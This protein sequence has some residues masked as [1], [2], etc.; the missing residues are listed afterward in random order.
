MGF[1]LGGEDVISAAFFGYLNQFC[2]KLP[3]KKSQDFLMAFAQNGQKSLAGSTFSRDIGVADC[4]I[5]AE[6]EAIKHCHSV[7]FF[8]R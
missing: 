4:M 6:M 1:F 2:E 3:K 5:R 8:P 7:I